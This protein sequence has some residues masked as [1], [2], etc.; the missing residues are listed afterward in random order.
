MLAAMKPIR[1]LACLLF[2]FPALALGADP[3]APATK[4]AN[5]ALP[6]PPALANTPASSVTNSVANGAPNGTKPS[7]STQELKVR[8]KALQQYFTEDEWKQV[9]RY[10]LDSALDGLQG[11]EEAAL[12]P[13]LTFRLEILKRRMA[14]EGNSLMDELSNQWQQLM[15]PPPPVPYEP[16]PLPIWNAPVYTP[17]AAVAR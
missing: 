5:G 14:V 1:R 3:V 12:A 11:T 6:S 2:M 15:T 17:P 16:R 10:L 8:F 7:V 4:A 13:D 9:S